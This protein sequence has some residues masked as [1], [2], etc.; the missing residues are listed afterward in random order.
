M[1]KMNAKPG[2]FCIKLSMSF[3]TAFAEEY[4]NVNFVVKVPIQKCKISYLQ[5][6]DEMGPFVITVMTEKGIEFWNPTLR[7]LA[8]NTLLG[9]IG[10]NSICQTLIT[11]DGSLIPKKDFV[12]DKEV[13]I[14]SLGAPTDIS[15]LKNL[16]YVLSQPPVH[17]ELFYDSF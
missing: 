10:A 12:G 11:P 1:K 7:N 13:N 8:V 5:I 15:D 16:R 14:K 2:Q 9:L 3:F 6:M 4:S 17:F